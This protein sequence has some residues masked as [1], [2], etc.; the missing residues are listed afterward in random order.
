MLVYN[1]KGFFRLCECET[2][3]SNRTQLLGLDCIICFVCT[4]QFLV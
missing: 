1:M 4:L 3:L 2:L